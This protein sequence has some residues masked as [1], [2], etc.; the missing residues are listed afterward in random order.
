MNRRAFFASA[1]LAPFAPKLARLVSPTP[2]F[3][4]IAVTWNDISRSLTP[5]WR[6]A[7]MQKM[8]QLLEKDDVFYKTIATKD[9]VKI[10]I[11]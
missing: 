2:V 3:Q 7:Q 9:K 5:M 11:P 8:R 6:N 10:K 4:R 1:F